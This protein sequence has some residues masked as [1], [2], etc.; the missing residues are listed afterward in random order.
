[1]K[2]LFWILSESPKINT[3]VL[4]GLQCRVLHKSGFSG[5]GVLV[6]ED[7]SSGDGDQ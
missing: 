3:D 2:P 5:P 4:T 7:S 1:M 6:A